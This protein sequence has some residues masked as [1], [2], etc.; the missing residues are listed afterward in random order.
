MAAHPL[1]AFPPRAVDVEPHHVVG[2]HLVVPDALRNRPRDF[3]PPDVRNFHGIELAIIPHGKNHAFLHQAETRVDGARFVRGQRVG[4]VVVEILVGHIV[5]LV[6]GG[7]DEPDVVEPEPVRTAVRRVGFHVA[8]QPVVDHHAFGVL[9]EGFHGRLHGAVAHQGGR[10]ALGDA[11][12]FHEHPRQGQH[13]DHQHRHRRQHFDQ[14][15]GVPARGRGDSI[16]ICRVNAPAYNRACRSPAR[17][18]GGWLAVP[19]DHWRLDVGH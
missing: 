2:Q 7:A 3:P 8:S 6:A 13:Q 14:R 10:A 4:D 18:A 9:Q 11:G 15:E 5:V 16:P 19:L 17:R 1:F 12:R